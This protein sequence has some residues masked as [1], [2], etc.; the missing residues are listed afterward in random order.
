MIHLSNKATNVQTPNWF[1]EFGFT[2]DT[3]SLYRKLREYEHSCEWEEIYSWV[4]KSTQDIVEKC[5]NLHIDAIATD[6]I[7]PPVKEMQENG[8]RCIV[9]PSIRAK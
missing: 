7:V 9:L 3:T 5:R 4:A 6:C 2:Y 8:I 1:I